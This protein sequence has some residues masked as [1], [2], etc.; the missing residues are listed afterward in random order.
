MA[1][2]VWRQDA[3]T[4]LPAELAPAS[5]LSLSRILKVTWGI[6]TGL[7][8]LALLWPTLLLKAAPAGL[9][10]SEYIA[11]PGGYAALEIFNGTGIPIDLALDDY[12][13]QFYFDG[14]GEAGVTIV[15]T[16]SVAAGET[17][18]LVP[19]A[20]APPLLAAADQ[21]C[22]QSFF[23]G[24][25]AV[26]LRQRE[27]IIDVIG[28]VGFNPGGAW[29]SEPVTTRDIILRRKAAIT[30]GDVNS[31]DLFEPALEWEAW[32]LAE[33]AG[34]G[35]HT[36]A[37]SPAPISTETIAGPTPLPAI[38]PS[39]GITVSSLITS[40][41]P[42]SPVGDPVPPAAVPTP[43]LP[44]LIG[45]FLYAGLIPSTE[46]DEF[47]E[48]CNPNEET[49]DLTG[50]KIGDESVIGG[51][52]SMY[53][54]LADIELAPDSCL[55]I[56]KNA[57]QFFARFGFFPDFELVTENEDYSDNQF[58]LNLNQYTAWAG[59]DWALAN[60]EDE[61]LVLGPG[62]ELIDSVAYG[63]ADYA[64]LALAPG[65][66][67][68]SPYSLQ[69]LWPGDTNSMGHD[70]VRALPSPGS[71]T[72][73]PP[74]P[75]APLPAILP[76]GMQ[77]FWGHLH[78]HSS[79]TD[80]AGPP[81]Y[82]LALARAAGLHFYAITD[83]GA[84]LDPLEWL[85]TLSQ[86]QQATVPGAFV[87]LRGVEWRHDTAGHITVFNSDT[88][89]SATDPWLDSLPELY[90]HLV[91]DSAALAQFNHPDQAEFDNFAFD[92]SASSRLAIQ[93]ISRDAGGEYTRF[94]TAFLTSNQQGWR[95]APTASGD[96]VAADGGVATTV[97]TGLVAPAL[98]E[99]DL[100]NA[101]R[102][103]RLFATED[104]NLALALRI[105]GTWMGAVLTRTGTVPA[106]VDIVDPDPEPATLFFYQGS[107][108]LATVPL[109]S[110]SGQW[111]SSVTA[112]PGQF[113]WLRLVQ[114]DGQAAYSAPIWVEGQAPPD[115][116]YLNEVLPAPRD[117]DWNGDGLT[118][119]QDEWFELFNPTDH[120]VDLDGW[121]L[122]DAAA[123]I[124][125]FPPGFVIPAGGF[126]VFYRSQTGLALNNDQDRLT[127]TNP[128][129][130]PVDSFDYGASP[131]YNGSWCRLP[132]GGSGWS[133]RC[134]PSP[135]ASNREKAPSGGPLITTIYEAKRLTPGAL[136]RIKGRVT[137]P[138]G[139]LGARYMYI[140]DSTAGILIYLPKDHRLYFNLGD[141]VQV[142][143]KL[144]LFHEEFEIAVEERD[145]VSFLEPGLPPQPLP[146]ATTSLLE[147]YEGLLVMLTGQAVRFL[148]QANLWLNDGTGEAKVYIKDSTGITRPWLAPNT[149]ATV[150]GIVSQYSEGEPSR[151]D[152]RLLPRYQG[153]LLFSAS[154]LPAPAWPTTLPETGAALNY[155]RQP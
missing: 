69:R 8:L 20:A 91:A 102:A 56:A 13:V 36:L 54:F 23:D 61:L 32:S 62:D 74:P 9:F 140:Q 34:L 39:P 123:T 53:Q 139:V 150:I 78:A 141:R 95:V 6:L 81:F 86:T 126:A 145:E 105:G 124:F 63:N 96:A 112:W 72:T 41:T 107:R 109:T 80:G 12:Q 43:A 144:R 42:V 59:G 44:V 82:A 11:G 111:T 49:I 40:T 138:P 22:E 73:P 131:G 132:D 21:L 16:G 89:L 108:L 65:A 100:L 4:A 125:N 35:A 68:S 75:A 115:V 50:Y 151:A 84:L 93:E 148:G 66:S 64:S 17:Y 149:P 97:R 51:G 104:A 152:Y 60:G 77:A 45:E 119:S 120:P 90:A 122:S 14:A 7:F 147:P 26:V 128:I 67:A 137:A 135:G 118:D 70:F 55:L 155:D 10:F 85:A 57:D 99:Q 46:G 106:V 1:T 33:L 98:T 24:N 143:G 87:G 5:S 136:V 92:P 48:L 101:I 117:W 130:A 153:D 29:G 58:V 127:L 47:L 19:R 88:L 27:M 52:E 83:P 134:E 94:E 28:Q 154:P 38:T 121:Q 114:A 146:I 129:A 71:L 18:I 113:F 15:L 3:G 110:S 133:D 76:E 103:R 31:T 37:A 79:Y 142:E 25:D 30:T 2:L 116:I